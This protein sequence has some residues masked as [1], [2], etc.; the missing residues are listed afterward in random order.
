M[1]FADVFN[2]RCQRVP[3]GEAIQAISGAAV[4]LQ[5]LGAGRRWAV[6]GRVGLPLSCCS[7]N[8]DTMLE[9]FVVICCECFECMELLTYTYID[10]TTQMQ[11]TILVPWMV[12][13]LTV[14]FFLIYMPIVSI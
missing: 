3:K 13:F 9:V 7:R 4:W 6:W 11:V 5:I 2:H 14:T 1:P 10:Y 12:C 8:R